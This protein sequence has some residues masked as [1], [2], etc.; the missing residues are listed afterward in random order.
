MHTRADCL[1]ADRQDPLAPLKQLFDLP[2]DVI[3]LDGNSLGVLPK[4][5]AARAAQ[6]IGQEWGN[7][8]IRSWNTAG[9]FELPARLG[10]KL[11]QLIGAG[12]GQVVVTDTT[13]LNLFKALAAALRIQQQAA[14]QRRVI[15]SER[16]NFPTDLYMIQGMIDLLQQG[17]ELRLIDDNLPLEQALDDSTAALLLSHVNYRTGAMYD[18][19]AV[20]AQA[21]ARGALAIW[22]L[23]HAAGAVPV[24]VTGANADF[25]VG[26][27]Y[28]Y[29]NAGPGAPAYIWVAP[30]HTDRFWQPLS[31]WWGHQ[32]PFDMTAT[33]EPAG[34][35]RRYLCGTQ[36][37][38]SLSLVECGLDVSLAAD[39][40]EVRK[41]SLALGDLFI[42]LTEN[43]CAGHPL[44]LV[45]P[46][47][48][49]R[50]GSHVSIR[51]PHGYAV[52]QALI[53]RGVIGDYREPE[54]LRFGLTPLYLGYA[55]VW[56]AVDVLKDVLDSEVWKQPQ[57]SQR[58][59][60]T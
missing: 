14:P 29:L 42:E 4:T 35:I 18:M 10:D 17:Y 53:A 31:G 5:A 20:T 8:L 12:Q 9:W 33:Y 43:R 28:K 25:A 24:D 34:G 26:C 44:T 7:G 32:R 51:H 39:M 47:E 15:V 22:D 45:T 41:K 52:M 40:N 30:R 19:A 23:A 36:P 59:A 58:G 3:Y 13:S 48:H 6:V 11:G 1:Q 56:D 2:P 57:F 37:I 38:V 27:T 50:R 54:V 21:H 60:V 55:D 16:D 49:A 46:R